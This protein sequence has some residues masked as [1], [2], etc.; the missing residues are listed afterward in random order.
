MQKLMQLL[1]LVAIV[2]LSTLTKAEAHL[3]ACLGSSGGG[4]CH[5]QCAGDAQYDLSVNVWQCCALFEMCCSSNG[6][7][8]YGD[9][10]NGFYCLGSG[11]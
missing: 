5:I 10:Q 7:A 4:Q 3:E 9:P 8:Y 6:T 2:L 1:A 11:S